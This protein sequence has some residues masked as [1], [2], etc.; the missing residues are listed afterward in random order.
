M[1]GLASSCSSLILV[2]GPNTRYVL[3]AG[4]LLHS[5]SNNHAASFV[6][7]ASRPS[8]FVNSPD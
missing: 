6:L 5:R 3:G 1:A 2:G 8:L 7:P 4:G